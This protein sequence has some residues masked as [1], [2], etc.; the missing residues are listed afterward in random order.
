MFVTSEGH[1][2]ARFCRA[3]ERRNLWGAEAG[4]GIGVR[5]VA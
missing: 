2:Y 1:A 5:E 3:I 4:E